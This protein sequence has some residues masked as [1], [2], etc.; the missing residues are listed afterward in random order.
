MEMLRR[1]K[2]TT[3]VLFYLLFTLWGVVACALTD[4]SVP[5]TEEENLQPPTINTFMVKEV[6]K[7]QAVISIS[8]DLSKAIEPQK[9]TLYYSR[10]NQIPDKTDLS[11]DL[12]EY[13]QSGTVT[14]TL[15]DLRPNTRYYCRLYIETVRGNIYSQA[16][17]FNTRLSTE[18]GLAWEKIADMPFVNDWYSHV[19]VVGSDAVYMAGSI[20]KEEVIAPLTQQGV[21]LFAPS[22][23]SWQFVSQIAGNKRTQAHVFF[24]NNYVFYGFG[25]MTNDKTGNDY[26]R[27]LWKYLP[28]ASVLRLQATLPY[29]V[30][31]PMSIFLHKGSIY[32]LGMPQ[33]DEYLPVFVMVYDP[34]AN[35]WNQCMDFPGKKQINTCSVVAGDRVFI[36]GGRNSINDD[37]VFSNRLW[38]YVP[39]SDT[40]LI[41]EDFPG[42]ARYDMRGFAIG[43]KAYFGYGMERVDGEL[44]RMNDLWV[45]DP[46]E[47]S[48]EVCSSFEALNKAEITHSFGYN[49]EGYIAT[50]QQELWKYT[51]DKDK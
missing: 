26:Q 38:E 49:G 31:Y 32:Y 2:K 5:N 46:A 3:R 23:M 15:A 11:L 47:D 25:N 8:L 39:E 24:L 17:E 1:I 42:G 22:Q 19:H 27:D 36:L 43:E 16:L 4:P 21:W 35:K 13:Y 34:V 51:P 50:S 40:W 18:G 41:R 30:A 45:Y 44:V 12:M 9:Y 28:E 7:R 37:A 29:Y 33:M 10:T 14:V 6:F 20:T 48:W